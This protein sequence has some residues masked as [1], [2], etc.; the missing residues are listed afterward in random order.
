MNN[1]TT[2]YKLSTLNLMQVWSIEANGQSLEIKY[3]KLHGNLQVQIEK[4]G[5]GKGGRSIQ[6]QLLSRERSRVRKQLDKGYKYTIEEANNSK[7]KN[8]LNFFKPMLA[9]NLHRTDSVNWRRVYAQ[10]KYDGHRALVTCAYGENIAYTRQGKIIPTISHVIDKLDIPE[11]VTIDGE[12]YIH[13]QSLQKIASTVKRYQNESVNLT[14]KVYDIISDTPYVERLRQLKS[15]KGIDIVPTNLIKKED[16][17]S[18]FL[19]YKAEGYEGLILR[20][21]DYP[22][23]PGKRCK[24]LLKVKQLPGYEL[25]EKEYKIIGVI[26]SKNNWA[27]LQCVTDEN[28]RFSVTAPGKIVTKKNIMRNK[29]NF[30]GRYVTIQYPQVTDMGV[31]FHAV[32]LRIRQDI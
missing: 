26:P 25:I 11:G 31:P 4:I 9:I 17:E 20:Q 27:I 6:D 10:P 13:G 24:S 15:I 7:G 32:A 3:G 21:N 28:M 12:L 23:A 29:I 19:K 14:Y 1:I 16:L 2:L 5:V 22:Y 30:L 18:T 8:A